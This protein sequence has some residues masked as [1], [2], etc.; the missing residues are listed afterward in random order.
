MQPLYSYL[1]KVKHYVLF[2]DITIFALEKKR[3]SAV[4]KLFG[5]I[6]SIIVAIILVNG[7]DMHTHVC[8]DNSMN[9]QASGTTDCYIGQTA[10]EYSLNVPRQ[11]Y[12]TNVQ[13]LQSSTKRTS[14]THKNNF[15]F[16]KT[17]RATSS[18]FRKFIDKKNLAGI[19]S[20][21]EPAHRLISFGRLII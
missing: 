14:N 9:E 21:A 10:P 2:P 18:G 5:L 16:I 19:L 1:K 13:Q 4:K 3:R 15:V 12:S 7:T 8:Q 6:F 11:I 20:L 17:G